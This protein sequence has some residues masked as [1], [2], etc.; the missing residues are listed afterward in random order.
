MVVSSSGDSSKLM[1]ARWNVLLWLDCRW[2]LGSVQGQGQELI[3]LQP[4][5]GSA[6]APGL[7]EGSVPGRG[8]DCTDTARSTAAPAPL[9]HLELSAQPPLLPSVLGQK[10]TREQDRL[11]RAPT[12]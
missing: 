8:Q 11:L 4:R 3:L 6:C 2:L 10:G 1:V 5:V 9:Q 12:S 7:Q